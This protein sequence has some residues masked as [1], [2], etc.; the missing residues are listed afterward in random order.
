[1]ARRLGHPHPARVDQT[2][3]P[4]TSS[5]SSSPAVWQRPWNWAVGRRY[6]LA[7]LLLYAFVLVVRAPWVLVLGRFWA[8]EATGYLAYAW[9]H[10]FLD[11]LTAPQYGYFNLVANA[12][13]IL[14]AHVPLE[15]APRFTTALALLVQL[16]PAAAI[17]FLS[18]PGLSTPLRKGSALLLL[19]VAPANPEV[20][21]NN[22]NTQHL[23]CAA[24]GLVLI[25][26]PGKCADRRGKW[27][28][29]GLAGLTGVACTLLAP[30]FWVQWWLERRRERLTQAVIISACALLQFVFISQALAQNQRRVRFNSTAM[31][32]AAYA[33]FIAMPLAPARL[34]QRHLAQLRETAEQT[35]SL[36]DWVWVV[37]AAGFAA[38]LLVCWRSGS[39]AAQLLAAAALWVGLLSFSATHDEKLLGHL[40]HALR[41]YYAPQFFF[42]LA[43]LVALA[44]GTSLPPV[45]K[46]LGALWLAA[47]LL[48]GLVNFACAPLDWPIIFSGPPWS[49]QVEQWRKDPSKPLAVWPIGWQFS[50]PPKP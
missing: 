41:Y 26:E 13:G 46:A 45:L 2:L 5:R 18:I 17:L 12:A 31:V 50:L 43:L 4:A 35:G 6:E 33:K 8:E 28:V 10:S 47:A 23:L 16:I 1:M 32:G 7:A 20:Y 25:S 14:A 44:P 15:A 22:I 38:F 3:V 36:P 49:R 19:L 34:A 11:A 29:L 27:V 21:L 39:R 37:T 24:G 30:L 9:N 42:L 48:M 40:T